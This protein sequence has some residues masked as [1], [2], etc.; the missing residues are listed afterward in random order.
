[1]DVPAGTIPVLLANATGR[2]S[3]RVEWLAI[4]LGPGN[5]RYALPR[6]MA[7]GLGVLWRTCETT[8]LELPGHIA[9]EQSMRAR[10]RIETWVTPSSLG[11][12]HPPAALSA[13]AWFVLTRSPSGT[14]PALSD[15]AFRLDVEGHNS[16]V[17][18]VVGAALADRPPVGLGLLAAALAH[19][20][21]MNPQCL[22]WAIREVAAATACVH[23][24]QR[25]GLRLDLP[26][27]L[28]V[29][30]FFPGI[31]DGR[32]PTVADVWLAAWLVH[33]EFHGFDRD[34]DGDI[35][36]L[37]AFT[38]LGFLTPTR[39]GLV[40][41]FA[42][43]SAIW[44]LAD[45][46]PTATRHRW[47]GLPPSV[48]RSRFQ[49]ATGLTPSCWL[50]AAFM[51]V[52]SAWANADDVAS[53]PVLNVDDRLFGHPQT[54]ASFRS[55]F[56][57]E[58]V[59]DIVGLGRRVLAQTDIYR[60]LGTTPQSEATALFDRP[61]IALP[62]GALCVASADGFAARAIQVIRE[63]LEAG[64]PVAERRTV[65]GAL[66]RMFEA[67]GADQLDR[68][69]PRHVVIHGHE[70]DERAGLYGKRGD[71]VVADQDAAVVLEFALQPTRVRA[72]RGDVNSI[73]TTLAAYR[74]KRAQAASTPLKIVFSVPH[75]DKLHVGHFVVT[76]APMRLSAAHAAQLASDD[77]SRSP[78][79]VI[80]IDEL[81]ELIDLT[82]VA[83][84]VPGALIA[85]QADDKPVPF[86]VHVNTLDRL[87]PC[88]HPRL[89]EAIEQLHRD[90]AGAHIN[91]A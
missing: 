26:A 48:L 78:M 14:I 36:A 7:G 76:D 38:A 74:N 61:V 58:M 46:H 21:W 69:K 91:A 68:L 64:V 47:N 17:N 63:V 30:E 88:R 81:T 25:V 43:W 50:G 73:H 89:G 12:R 72:A 29:D 75:L 71:A 66:G 5:V 80:S 23:D 35:D 77:P 8:G 34:R 4:P 28:V 13:A 56:A 82:T 6:S 90:A 87:V 44:H 53:H 42:T 22:R 20:V 85:W 39:R 70:I 41:R 11:V 60:G 1:M 19:R 79:F 2:T 31:L 15:V 37:T 32:P 45:D 24:G 18:I 83:L 55:L 65:G 57:A 40:E 86:G 84:S 59:D 62:N 10:L 51:S 3:A 54:A 16:R 67:Y 33:E 9:D 52:V 49:N 27:Q